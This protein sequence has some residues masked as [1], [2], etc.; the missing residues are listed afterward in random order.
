MKYS[1]FYT[2]FSVPTFNYI[3][4]DRYMDIPYGY[5]VGVSFLI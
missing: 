4:V 2:N 5:R 3:L 1:N